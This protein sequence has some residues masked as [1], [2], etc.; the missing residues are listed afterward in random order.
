MPINVFSG[1][2]LAESPVAVAEVLLSR[3]RSALEACPTSTPIVESYVVLG[4]IVWDE[5]CGILAAAPLRVYN[6]R[7]FP[8]QAIDVTSCDS[9]Q[10][11]V[12]VAII[13]LYCA[14]VI[15]A[16]GNVPSIEEMS[17]SFAQTASDAAVIYNDLTGAMPQGWE[18]ANVE[19]TFTTEGGCVV[20][21]T[22]ITVGL[23]QMDWCACP[24]VP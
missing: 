13:A 22:R 17:A 11:C 21:D 18:R 10:L 12:E 5:C 8:Q 9:S 2:L 1:E 14:P 23:P 19:Q 20:V 16:Q 6:S 15:D 3:V 4:E 24:E 7:L